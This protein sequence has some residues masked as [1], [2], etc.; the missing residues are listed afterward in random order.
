MTTKN[1][2]FAANRTARPGLPFPGSIV[3][4]LCNERDAL[5]LI[6]A[7]MRPSPS[8]LR[9]S[10]DVRELES[11]DSMREAECAHR[12]LLVERI[13]LIDEALARLHLGAYGSCIECG[14]AIPAMR[15][16]L[17]PATPL[18]IV[19]QTTAEGGHVPPSL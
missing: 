9:D 3:S 5:R 10:W 2:A 6:L 14:E 1:T 12:D 13:E 16:Q 17:D 4:R 18:C 8:D 11:E 19:C 7:G 15:L